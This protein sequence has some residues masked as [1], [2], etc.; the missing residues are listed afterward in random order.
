RRSLRASLDESNAQ[1]VT[2]V[3]TTRY[4][5]EA[6]QL[7]RNI[8]IIDGGPIIRSSSMRKL[9]KQ[10]HVETFLLDCRDA[11][12]QAPALPGFPCVLADD[13]TLEVQV[14]KE[15]GM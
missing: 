8:A 12:E 11:M 1:D 7:C 2:I 13:H 6:E 5:E 14:D 15:Q 9:L 3:R 4:L 10:L